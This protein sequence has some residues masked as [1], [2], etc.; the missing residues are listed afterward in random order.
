MTLG[1]SSAAPAAIIEV[2][3]VRRSWETERSSA[4]LQ[5]VA[6]AQRLGLDRLRL[7]PVA[8]ARQLRQLRQGPVGLLAAALGLGGAGA[9]QLGQGA[10][11]DRDDRE[12]DQGD[13]VVVGG[14]VEARRSAAGGTS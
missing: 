8:L 9:G 6:A 12:D 14:D 13:E 11:G 10:A 2:S 4:G 1:E 3:G 5:L 7:H